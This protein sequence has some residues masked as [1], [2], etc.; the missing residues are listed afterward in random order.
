MVDRFSRETPMKI[1]TENNFSN[2]DEGSTPTQIKARIASQYAAN[3]QGNKNASIQ[4][5]S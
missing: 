3:R 4:R 5:H 1:Y 2:Q